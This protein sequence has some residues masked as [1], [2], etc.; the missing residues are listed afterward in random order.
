[1]SQLVVGVDTS[2]FGWLGG[3]VTA[4][5]LAC[6]V[7]WTW[8]AYAPRHRVRHEITSRLPLEGGDDERP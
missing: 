2:S 8:W 7:G 3:T 6:F 1:V 4:L 5:F